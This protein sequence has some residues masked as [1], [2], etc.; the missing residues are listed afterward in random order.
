M[1][2]SLERTARQ[3]SELASELLHKS[4]D[5]EK[6]KMELWMIRRDRA[7][8]LC[9]CRELMA[10]LDKLTTASDDSEAAQNKELES[11]VDR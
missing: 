8:A 7:S 4:R 10:R 9:Q 5:L 1:E 11:N 2:N 3:Q 6:L